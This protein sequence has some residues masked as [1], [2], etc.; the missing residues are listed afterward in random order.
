MQ[1]TRAFVEEILSRQDW[2]HTFAY[3]PYVDSLLHTNSVPSPLQTVQLKA[4]LD[5]L[6]APLAE[7]QSNLDL[8]RDAVASLENQMS[9]LQPYRRDYTRILSSIRYIPPEILAKILCGSWE[10][11]YTG[12]DGR[13][14]EISVF[15]IREGPWCLGQVCSSWR[16]VVETLCPELWAT[17][18]IDVPGPCC[19]KMKSISAEILSRVLERS[20]NH[21]LHFSFFQYSAYSEQFQV[22]DQC[23]DIMIMHSA[24]WETA[25]IIVPPSF[26]PRLSPI[27]RKIDWLKDMDLVCNRSDDLDSGPESIY[28]FEIAPKLQVLHLKG[29]H[30]DAIIRFP[31]TNLISFS[32]QRPWSGDRMTPE[33]LAIVKSAQKL[34]SFSYVD[35]GTAGPISASHS[36]AFIANSSLEELSTCSRDFMRSVILPALKEVTLKASP[37]GTIPF[38]YPCPID[39]LR[40]LHEMLIH[41]QCS[42]TQLTLCEAALYENLH[43]ILRLSPQLEEFSSYIYQ[44]WTDEYDRVMCDLVTQMKET[45]MVR[46]SPQHCLVPSLQQFAIEL[47]GLHFATLS[48]LDLTFVEMV[49][50]RVHGPCVT[51]WLTKLILW[52]SESAWTCLDEDDVLALEKLKD[53]GLD[54]FVHVH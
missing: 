29:M 48:F 11:R 28:A 13:I 40:G 24:R 34:R 43:A 12:T 53:E 45:V 39:A 22:V 46:G 3:P 52:V 25:K 23:F 50:L 35:Y 6:E 8:L 19:R 16:R 44:R 18:L 9:R 54:G 51:Q 5:D 4:S 47:N 42:L 31:T 10:N 20:R 17:V 38:R 49:A 2:I 7:V 32:D 27:R 37:S 41:S 14:S 30:P 36:L 21:P 33:Y 1:P 15:S 26:I